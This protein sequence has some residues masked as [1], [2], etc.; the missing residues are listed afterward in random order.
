MSMTVVVTRNVSARVRGFLASAMLELA[1]GVYSAPRISPAVRCRIWQVLEDW[2]PNEMDAS[3]VM[4][5]QERDMPGGQAVKVLGS[6]PIEL[7]EIDGIVLTKRPL[8]VTT[9]KNE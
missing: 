6:P 2:F 5:W 9:E 4:V 3:V 1:P 8:P 7:V